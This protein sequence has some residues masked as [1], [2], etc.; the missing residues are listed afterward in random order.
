MNR[1][2]IFM[3]GSL[4]GLSQLLSGQG[5]PAP[6]TLTGNVYGL[7]QE[8]QKVALEGA[9]LYWQDTQMGTLS[10]SDGSFSL[11]F[12]ESIPPLIVSYIGYENDTL[13]VG[14]S[15]AISITL[16]QVA[17][18]ET[19]TL[20]EKRSS[21]GISFL[22]PMKTELISESEL[23]KAAC[24]NLSESFET[25]PSV[26]VAF[27]D[28]VTGTRTIQLLGL[29]GPYTQINREAIPNVR[30]LSSMYGLTYIPGTWVEG[31]QLN[32][33][34]GSVANGFESIAGQINVELRKPEDS[35][36]L[37]LN[38]YLNRMGR[39]EGNANFSHKFKG[40]SWSTATLLHA[41]SNQIRNDRNE[42]G[43]LDNP[44][45]TQLVGLNRWKR[46]GEKGLM[47][48]L[49]IQGTYVDKLGGQA[50]FEPT[51]DPA[52]VWGFQLN[53]RRVEGWAKI[54]KV[55]PE[56]PWRTMGIQIAGT[57]HDQQSDFGPNAYNANQQSLYV[58]GLYQGIFGNSNHKWR[59]GVSLMYD[60]YQEQLNG[61]NYD[62]TEIVPGAFFEYTYNFLDIFGLVAG[63]RADYHNLFGAFVT[64]R[65]HLRY[66]PF[67]KT[68]LRLSGGRGQRTA[69]ILAEN[70][71][72]LASARQITIFGDGGNT[73]Y[74]LQPEVAWN[75]G[76][77]AT[78]YFR[79]DYRD[80]SIAFDLYR[81]DFLNQIV[82]DMDASPQE[83]RFYNLEGQSYSNSMQVQ[84]EYEV[85]KRVD[86][87][88][89]YRWFD[90][91]TTYGDQLLQKPLVSAHRAFLN[92]AYETRS[93]WKF[94]AT[95][96][97]QGSKRIPFT[98]SNPEP[99]RLPERSPDFVVVNAQVS[100]LFKG[101]KWEV[102]VGGENLLNFRQQAPIL[103]AEQPFSEFFDSSL[104]WGP[105]FGRNVYAGFRYRLPYEG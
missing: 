37:Y 103:S 18:L 104:V 20:E 49:G 69:N 56:K 77:N 85:F 12:P 61:T 41:S 10:R 94:D 100:K 28:A 65:L 55:Y 99:Y 46:V 47:L 68:V 38:G 35:D 13:E 1:L 15:A 102:Y 43:F 96:N 90:V 101:K 76:F 23:L 89:A 6:T 45:G 97:W 63:L 31:L 79:L 83:V 54:G 17:T 91:R 16:E 51:D 42:D 30:G 3:L 50:T 75:Y 36:R 92:L 58:N 64:P 40:G 29:A 5:I 26:D 48:Q 60:A 9:R 24:C 25:S 62:R 84:L 78:Q 80:G 8:G 53:T 72:L 22:D 81:T 33:G 74:G 66:T 27:T 52:Q 98:E 70:Q 87:R 34:T 39:M 11:P 32:K 82:I 2:R 4:L 14:Q 21:T 59:S 57:Y 88:L 105:I 7:D 95:V 19:V 86:M 93:D 71:G 67:E 73:P 44:L